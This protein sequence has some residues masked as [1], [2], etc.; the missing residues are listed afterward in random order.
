MQKYPGRAIICLVPPGIHR[1]EM[2]FFDI[3]STKDSNLL[4]HAIHS[5]FCWLILLKTILYSGFRNPYKEI[6]E[7]RK[8]EPIHEKPFVVRKSRRKLEFEKRRSRI[9]SLDWW[10]G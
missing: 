9:P 1:T 10:C 5:P 2:E 3:N 4:F 8:L 7:T 6:S